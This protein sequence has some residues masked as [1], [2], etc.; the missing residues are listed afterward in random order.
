MSGV[1][2]ICQR[3]KQPIRIHESLSDISPAA[4]DLLTGTRP[5]VT[6]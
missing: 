3:C 5:K 1:P 6:D 2:F 4:L